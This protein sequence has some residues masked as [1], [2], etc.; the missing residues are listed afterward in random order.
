MLFTCSALSKLECLFFL[1]TEKPVKGPGSSVQLSRGITECVTTPPTQSW[2]CAVFKME[3]QSQS[4]RVGLQLQTGEQSFSFKRKSRCD[5]WLFYSVSLY[6]SSLKGNNCFKNFIF[7]GIN[8]LVSVHCCSFD[9]TT[10]FHCTQT[11]DTVYTKKKQL[12]QVRESPKAVSKNS[13]NNVHSSKSSPEEGTHD[14]LGYSELQIHSRS[15]NLTMR[16]SV[17]AI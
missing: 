2:P 3:K 5:L 16:I 12:I 17:Q 1:C 7:I 10:R 8:V 15:G 11:S 14:F 4:S 9:S 13:K 6:S